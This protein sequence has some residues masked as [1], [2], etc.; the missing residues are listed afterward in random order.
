MG[1]IPIA[2]SIKPD[3][4]TTLTW[5]GAWKSSK[6]SRVLDGKWT[7]AHPIGR[8]IED[9]GQFDLGGPNRTTRVYTFSLPLAA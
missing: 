5:L 4:S 8:S 3:D 1:S 6:R 2:R 9:H 7:E